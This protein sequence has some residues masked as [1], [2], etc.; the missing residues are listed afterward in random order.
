MT[1]YAN[2]KK[3]LQYLT[4]G[5]YRFFE[6]TFYVV[7]GSSMDFYGNLQIIGDGVTLYTAPTLY[8]TSKPVYVR[9]NVAGYNDIQIILTRGGFG[10]SQYIFE[11]GLANASFVK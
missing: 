6:A 5:Q 1:G 9:V 7:S 10:D 11:T 3:T 8:K 2:S 4:S